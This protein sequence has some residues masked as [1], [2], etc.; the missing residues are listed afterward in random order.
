[1]VPK[2]SCKLAVGLAI[3][4]IGIGG[5]FAALQAYSATAGASRAP[6]NGAIDF[7]AAHRAPGRPLLVMA[8]HPRCPCTD[9][10]LVEL[11]D[12]LARSQ[13]ACD[14][15]ILQY[16]PTGWPVGAASQSLGGVRV[17]VVEDPEGRMAAILGA[18]TSGHC[19]LMDDRG[20]IRFYGGLTIA[21]GHVGRSPAQDA[22]LRIVAGGAGP[23]SS[24]PVYGCALGPECKPDSSL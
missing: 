1:M 16:H 2:K 15:L 10:S 19:V 21:R 8:V 13:G 12:L 5:G 23:L 22:I 17:P 6:A 24:A 9:A 7:L 18:E 11:G 4:L 3:W 20:V 14:A